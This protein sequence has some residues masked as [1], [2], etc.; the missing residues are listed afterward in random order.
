M[1]IDRHQVIE[2]MGLDAMAGVIEQR[3]V[4]AGQ[5]LAELLQRGVE[6][7][8]VEIEPGPPPTT[9][10][11]SDSSVSDISLASLPELGS[12]GTV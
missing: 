1:G 8:L 10:K 5:L 4:G 6:A 3:D 11:P 7:V 12:W 2:A 9:K